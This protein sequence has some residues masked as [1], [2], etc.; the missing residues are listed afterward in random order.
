MVVVF[1]GGSWDWPAQFKSVNDGCAGL[2]HELAPFDV[3]LAA[4]GVKCYEA[5]TSH[6]T[7]LSPA[8]AGVRDLTGATRHH[9]PKAMNLRPELVSTPR[10][11]DT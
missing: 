9:G 4:P 10:R 2:K 7:Y 3:P 8:R 6:R 5:V 1:M 11:A